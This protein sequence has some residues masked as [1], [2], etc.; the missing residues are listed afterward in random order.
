VEDTFYVTTPIY[1]VND[2]PHIGHAYTTVLADVVARYHRMMEEKVFFLTGTDEHGQKVAEAA[3]AR[4]V[5]PRQHCDEMVRQFQDLWRKLSISNDDFIR[6]T[7]PRHVAVVRNVLDRLQRSGDIYL[8]TYDGWYCA[9][10][11]RFWT[12]KDLVDGR[13]YQDWLI[14]HV[15]ENPSF[16]L[17]E[18]RRNEVLGFLQKPLGDLCISR[19]R[20]RLS[21]G[22]PLPFDEDYVTYVWFDALLNYISG[23]G[24]DGSEGTGS[25]RWP[26]DLHLIGK[27]I[28]TTHC[29]YWPTMLKAAAIPMPRSIYAHGWWLTEEG[30]MSKSRGRVVDPLDLLD[31][32]GPDP[33]RYFLMREMTPGQDATFSEEALVRRLNSDLANNLGNLHSRVLKMVERHFGA[34]VPELAQGG[35]AEEALRGRSAKVAAAV[36]TEVAKLR[37][38]GAAEA[39]IELVKATNRHLEQ[40]APWKLVAQSGR[41]SKAGTVLAAACETLR[42]ASC[43]LHPM[44]PSRCQRLR[45]SLGLQGLEPSFR[46]AE[47][48]GVLGAGRQVYAGEPLFPRQIFAD[49][50]GA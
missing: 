31:R 14:R 20:A 30:K 1:Y 34:R 50:S 25:T 48:W 42:V 28:V 4:G 19:P 7:E 8:G 10:E 38:N 35:E 5:E 22:I 3:K 43:L 26:A 24:H 32:Y 36:K 29:V 49:A 23:V 2:K 39:T 17:P 11:E 45:E 46:E 15:S 12:E 33:F 44:M 13:Q 37:V 9:H 41:K 27:D 16:V 21:W 18:A 6:T 40:Q 47:R